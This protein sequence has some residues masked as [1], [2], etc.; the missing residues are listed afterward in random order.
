LKDRLITAALGI[1]ALLVML[2]VLP[3]WGTLVLMTLI[4]GVGVYELFWKAGFLRNLR[5][6]AVTI[7]MECAVCVWSYLEMPILFLQIAIPV[8]MLYLFVE[9]LATELEM[10]FS[11]LCVAIFAGIV[12]P[13]LLSAITRIRI[14]ESGRL[15]VLLP[16]FMTM[17]PD[18]GA[19]TA[20]CLFG[21]HKLA[22]KISPKKTIEGVYGGILFGIL[23]VVLYGVVLQ[24]VF[25]YTVNYLFC[26]VYGVLGAVCSVI[27]DL[28]FSA[29]KRQH[30]IKDFSNMLPGHGG[31]LDRFDSAAVVAPVAEVLL[32]LL[33]FAVK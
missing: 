1:P 16:F 28:V 7:L 26:V 11:N 18:T 4:C 5:I 6:M 24:L 23:G 3:E 32:L 25:G 2:L 22:P 10:P 8:F 30:G 17:L 29:I 33:P 14:M 19:F 12:L 31:A 27:G 20:G 15:F 13:Y 21:K 9:Y